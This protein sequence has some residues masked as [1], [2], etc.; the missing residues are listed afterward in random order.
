MFYHLTVRAM[1]HYR[2]L[3]GVGTFHYRSPVFQQWSKLSRF[4]FYR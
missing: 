4:L 2:I 1:F 3:A